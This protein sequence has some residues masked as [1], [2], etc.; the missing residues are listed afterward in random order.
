MLSFKATEIVKTMRSLKKDR[1]SLLDNFAN[2]VV[3]TA[4]SNTPVDTGKAR[5]GWRKRRSRNGYNIDNRTPYVGLL[6]FDDSLGRPRSRQAP[7]GII[8]P[9]VKATRLTRRLNR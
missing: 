8:K 3:K 4:K 6:D 5:R 9:T 1:D 7:D 2:D